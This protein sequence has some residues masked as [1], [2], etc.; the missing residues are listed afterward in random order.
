MNFR[1]HI[2]AVT[3]AYQFNMSPGVSEAKFYILG[4]KHN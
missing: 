2:Q 4:Y 1:E 3:L